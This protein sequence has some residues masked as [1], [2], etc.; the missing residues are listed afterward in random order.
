M[1]VYRLTVLLLL[2]MFLS[3]C[4]GLK[5][6]PNSLGKNLTIHTRA[7][8]GS[9][10]SSLAVSLD[11]YKVDAQCELHYEGTVKLD[12]DTLE[13][14][15]PVNQP[16]LFVFVF[17]GSTF[18]ASR[19]SRMEYQTLFM[20]RG[21]TKYRVDVHYIDDIYDVIIR[22]QRSG[23]KKG[24]VVPHRDLASCKPG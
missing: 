19:S 1:K 16:S 9:M 13:V 20:P 4:S 21:R 7:D 5:T 15:L 24:K 17:N 6:Y 3:A 22:A 8:S 14:G 23:R 10:F 2:M 12:R 18:L 11:I